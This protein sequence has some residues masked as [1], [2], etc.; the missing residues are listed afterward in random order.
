MA[1]A[2]VVHES[3]SSAPGFAG[4]GDTGFFTDIG[5]RSVSIIV[6]KHVVAVVGDEEITEAVVVVVAD[7]NALAPSGV[8]QSQLSR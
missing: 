7:A 4:A 2:V 6:V 3:A 5:E 8:H 1:V